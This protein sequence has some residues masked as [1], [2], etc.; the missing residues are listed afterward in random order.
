MPTFL[1]VLQ[2]FWQK[3]FRIL[4]IFAIKH[5]IRMI[6]TIL[7]HVWVSRWA[8]LFLNYIHTRARVNYTYQL[9][10]C[11]TAHLAK[12]IKKEAHFCVYYS[13]KYDCYRQTWLWIIRFNAVSNSSMVCRLSHFSSEI[14]PAYCA[15]V[16]LNAASITHSLIL[17]RKITTKFWN[18]QINQEENAEKHCFLGKRHKKRGAFLRL[19]CPPRGSSIAIA[20]IDRTQWRR[21]REVWALGHKKNEP[22]LVFVSP[23]RLELSTHWLRVS[24]STNWARETCFF[25][26][27]PNI[28]AFF[29]PKSAFSVIF[30]PYKLSAKASA[31]SIWSILPTSI[32]L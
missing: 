14:V 17:R 1:A 27:W 13:V 2:I 8:A 32:I 24:C 9:L 29:L 31:S 11:S 25:L 4:N 15:T 12:D 18:K 5:K 3:I 10:I 21:T 19:L 28:F 30:I 22:R 23:E 16:C 7:E 20:I 6:S 26:I